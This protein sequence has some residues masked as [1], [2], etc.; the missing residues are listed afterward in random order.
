MKP[1]GNSR[2]SDEGPSSVRWAPILGHWSVGEDH[3]AYNGGEQRFFA[4]GQDFP[5]GILVNNRELLSG[6]CRVDVEFDDVSSGAFVGGIILGYR[7]QERYYLQ[8]Q[9]GAAQAA[10]S[11]SE[12]VSGFGW[13]PLKLAGLR[14]ALEAGRKYAL[15]VSLKGQEL[16]VS[17]DG[18]KVLEI[19]IPRPLEGKQTGL[20]A[21][22]SHAV[23]FSGFA[24]AADRPRA[25]VAMEYREPFDTFYRE[26]I[27]PHAEKLYEVVR[28][29]EKSGPG[30]IFQDMQREIGQSDVVIAEITPANPN[31][32]YE[33]GYAQALGKP[34]IL[35]AQRGGKLPFDIASYRV[36]FYDDSIGGKSRVEEDLAKHLDAI[37]QSAG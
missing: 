18:V 6:A 29:D 15:D 3:I 4:H 21:A 31:V 34:T 13:L 37:S 28:I 10:Y 32:F 26:V 19:L 1:N 22:G 5:M 23:R 35:L 30:I 8:V 17:V 14:D 36:V 9:L 27:R 24:A 25:F 20:I 11:V 7:S 33:L 2:V 12:F 16:R